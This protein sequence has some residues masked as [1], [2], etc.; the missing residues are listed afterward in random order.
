MLPRRPSSPIRANLSVASVGYGDTFSPQ[1]PV[2]SGPY[3]Q[4]QGKA[5]VLLLWGPCC[6]APATAWSCLSASC[7]RGPILWPQLGPGLLQLPTHCPPVFRA[8]S[9]RVDQSPNVRFIP[10]TKAPASSL[11]H[12]VPAA[13][14]GPGS[15]ST[16]LV[17][18]HELGP[19]M[20]PTARGGSGPAGRPASLW[21]QL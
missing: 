19:P 11:S 15:P 1:G 6:L 5:L 18:S 12:S 21:S 9:F 20:L 7:S 8:H 17:P 2:F 10:Q 14:P 16:A 3:H 4:V 13:S